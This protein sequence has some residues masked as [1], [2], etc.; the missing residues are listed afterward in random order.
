MPRLAFMG[1]LRYGVSS[2]VVLAYFPI[3]SAALPQIGSCMAL[4][5]NVYGV[6]MEG[7]ATYLGERS[8]QILA[9][10]ERIIVLASRLCGLRLET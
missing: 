9:E 8:L 3:R 5:S 7:G 1:Q 10:L 6:A 2:W 4:N